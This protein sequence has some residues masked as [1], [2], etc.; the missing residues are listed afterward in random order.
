M[1]WSVGLPVGSLV[2]AWTQD[3]ETQA[4]QVRNMIFILQTYQYKIILY[5]L[6]ILT[7]VVSFVGLGVG[8]DVGF[9][10]GG[11]VGTGEPSYTIS[12]SA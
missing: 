3:R 4:P 8:L 6:L 7:L 1:G 10:V 2:G 11:V 12:I 5:L 9:L